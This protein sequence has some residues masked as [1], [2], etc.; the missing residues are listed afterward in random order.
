L[1]PNIGKNRLKR[2]MVAVN[3]GDRRETHRSAAA[4]GGIAVRRDQ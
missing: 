2:Q 1:C 4:I 3:I